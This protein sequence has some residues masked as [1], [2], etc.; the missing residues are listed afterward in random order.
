MAAHD[1]P[2]FVEHLTGIMS[3]MCGEPAA[4]AVSQSL[5]R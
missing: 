4:L 5:A 1:W 2:H 3:S